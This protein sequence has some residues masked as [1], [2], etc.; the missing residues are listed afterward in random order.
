MKQI[1]QTSFISWIFLLSLATIWGVNF[2]FIKLAVEEIGPIT[3]VFLRLLMAS[4]I[5]YVVMK[6]QKQKLVLKPKLIL[7]YFILF[8]K[9]CF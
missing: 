8:A 1:N 7:F 4:I 9:L 2:L 5:L 3:N 6:L